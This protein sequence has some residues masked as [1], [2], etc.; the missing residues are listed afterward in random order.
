MQRS[1]NERN[2]SSSTDSFKRNNSAACLFTWISAR[3][4]DFLR[5][6]IFSD[7]F[8]MR[9]VRYV[10]FRRALC[11]EMQVIGYHLRRREEET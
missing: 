8:D 4:H 2:A 7:E 1:L 5:A 11:I 3:K 10:C 6:G 9:Y